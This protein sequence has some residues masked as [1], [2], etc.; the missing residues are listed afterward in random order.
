MVLA[1][2]LISEALSY[3][4]AHDDRLMVAECLDWQA[5]IEHLNEDPGVLATAQQALDICQELAVV[6]ARTLVRILGRIGAISVAQHRWSAAIQAYES[7]VSA[8]GALQDLS[9]TGQDVQ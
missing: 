7:A 2:P 6:P 5:A 1:Q 3:Y 9:R 4:G 8:G